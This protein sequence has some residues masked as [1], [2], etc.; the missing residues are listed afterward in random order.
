MDQSDHSQLS[1]QERNLIAYKCT[2]AS[3]TQEVKIP[4]LSSLPPDI[5]KNL[6]SE[7]L[8]AFDE[9]FEVIS[10]IIEGDIWPRFRK[11]ALFESTKKEHRA[12]LGIV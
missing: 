2:T 1:V 6:M 10:D 7:Y 11:S 12:E 5:V 4:D 8:A 9:C 3:A